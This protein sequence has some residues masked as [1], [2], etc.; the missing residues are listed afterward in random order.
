MS[1]ILAA[2]ETYR[3]A[4]ETRPHRS[5]ATEM[6]VAGR[7]REAVRAGA[8]CPDA[9]AA[10]LAVAGQGSR[11]DKSER[12]SG[13]SQRE[14]EVLRLIVRGLTAKAA[15]E[16]LEIAPKTA[17]NHIQNLYSKIGVTTRAGAALF[18]VEN[19]LAS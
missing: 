18:A 3:S 6:A 16:Q 8:L 19:G 5:A 17:E 10:V 7:L 15:A 13:L 12:L 11:R 9:A 2:A 14:I 4:C 1:R